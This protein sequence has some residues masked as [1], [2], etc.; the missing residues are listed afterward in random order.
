MSMSDAPGPPT[1]PLL[2]G[3]SHVVALVAAAVL[4]G[5]M[6]GLAPGTLA[7]ATAIVYL[8]GLCAM[9]GVSALYHRVS[10]SPAARARMGRIDHSTIFAAIAGTYTPVAAL[11]L[12]GWARTTLLALVWGGAVVGVALQWLPI[13]LPRWLFTSI[14]ALVGWAAVIALPQLHDALGTVGLALLAGGGLAYTLGAVVYALQRPD[15]WPSVFGFH[16]VFHACTV[17]GAGLHL[18][19]VGL[20]VLPRA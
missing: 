20:V 19:V 16:E 6:V 10:W 4:C 14:Y 18:A 2:R 13:T 7:R 1:H 3:W 9:F 12:D 8:V 5:L 11:G 17:V 15:P